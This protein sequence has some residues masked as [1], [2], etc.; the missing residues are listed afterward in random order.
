[1]YFNFIA[2]S[3]NYLIAQDRL[4][5]AKL[6]T[7]AGKIILIQ[8]DVIQIYL[9]I[10]PDGFITNVSE[11]VNKNIVPTVIFHI[12]LIDIPL[13]LL[14]F[15]YIFSY[16]Q[17][18]GDIEFANIILQLSKSLRLDIEYEL[19]KIF[20]DIFSTQIIFSINSTMKKIKTVYRALV[21]NFVEYFVEEQLILVPS[22]ILIDFTKS[23]TKLSDDFE[24][25][26]KR[27]EKLRHY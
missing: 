24:C 4:T 23:I 11:V 7:H 1:M 25:L 20:G 16:V 3:I 27:V 2:T 14:N 13:I 18:K 6:V 5:H 15:E 12:K 10:A 9:L 19:S 17:I 8:S 26:F 22:I 21:E